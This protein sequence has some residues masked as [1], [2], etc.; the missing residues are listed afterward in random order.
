M[1]TPRAIP[2]WHRSL[3]RRRARRRFDRIVTILALGSAAVIG[4][5][6]GLGAPAISPVDPTALEDAGLAPTEDSQILADEAP[7]PAVETDDDDAD[8]RVEDTDPDSVE[9]EA[10]D[11]PDDE[12][13]GEGHGEGDGQ[14]ADDTTDTDHGGDGDG[15]GDNGNGNGREI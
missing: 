10:D 3:M 1:T 2:S 4:I 6:F 11:E 9:E 15:D 13:G 5:A 7:A 12:T 8:A 14:N